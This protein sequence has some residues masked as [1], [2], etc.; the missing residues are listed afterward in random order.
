MSVQYEDWLIANQRYLT[1]RL[2]VIRQALS[3]A[4]ST[5][6]GGPASTSTALD[7]VREAA[8]AMPSRAALDVLCSSFCL[9]SFERDILLM[10]AGVELDSGLASLCAAR[11]TK[12]VGE[13]TFSLA[14]SALPDPHW[15]ALVPAGPLR[16][17]R[18]IE[19][20]SGSALTISPL[21]IDERVLHY[22]TGV[23]H[24][25]E[26]LQGI[27]ES[28]PVPEELPAS[29]EK[30]AA[31]IQECWTRST[32]MRAPVIHLDGSDSAGKRAVAAFACG[33]I[34]LRLHVMDGAEIPISAAE[35][36]VLARLWQ[37]EAI[38]DGSALF[39]ACEELENTRPAIAF[40]RRIGG[41]VV[42]GRRLPLGGTCGR[43]TVRLCVN[44][45][46]TLEQSGLWRRTLGDQAVHLNGAVERLVAQF[47]LSVDEIQS[48]G[49]QI[50]LNPDAGSE[51]GSRLWNTCRVHT[52]G[53]L[54]ELAQ[55]IDA[56][57]QWQDLVLPT[58]QLQ[59]L[60]EIAG[61]VQQRARVYQD[62]GF[63]A[64]GTRG[65][66]I[67]ALFAGVSGTGKTMAAEVL[68]AELCLDLY[69]IDLSQVVSKYI[70]ETEKNLR[71]VFDAAEG[72]GA[73]LLFDEADALFGT[74][75][76]VKDSHDRYANIEISY[77]LQRMECYRGLAILTTNM[78]SAIDAA[79]VR[80]LRFIVQFPFPDS[81][82]RADI[83]RKMFP[84]A[85][86]VADLDV[87]KLARLHV[88]GGNIR[89]IALHAAFLA[90]EAGGP[91]TMAHL[92]RGA[93][94]EYAKLEKQLPE[95]ECRDW[96]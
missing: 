84:A 43:Q 71:R 72:G 44:R 51:A 68:A 18:L 67:S 16:H 81:V 31:T 7:D 41:H 37:R 64:K 46:N 80:R 2:A 95:S 30:L 36:D 75:T 61:Q 14:L 45:P 62:W 28:E 47:D 24:L 33:L 34:G 65:L 74:R 70:G 76:E 1:A 29:H 20:G 89:N 11:G 6:G 91:V 86:P 87:Q 4:A 60:R 9:S 42:V 90:A 5:G 12:G 25:D 55:R 35:R 8:L 83:W 10:C 27:V 22:V 88:A 56:V 63:A 21:K 94:S 73:I 53:R 82:Q 39:V 17:W 50:P 66:G 32:S 13:P 15:S 58:A 49:R 78:K 92:L 85:T 57:A 40:L 26:R 59:A 3:S 23:S 77:L 79:F 93:R 54:D 52:R 19:V 38:L 69:R 48:T 96:V